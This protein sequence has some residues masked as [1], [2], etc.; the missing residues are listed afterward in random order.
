MLPQKFLGL[1][2]GSWNPRLNATLGPL[3]TMAHCVVVRDNKSWKVSA[4]AVK[5][6]SWKV[7]RRRGFS[8][9]SADKSYTLLLFRLRWM[10]L[11]VAVF[12]KFTALYFFAESSVT[13]AVL[14]LLF[15]AD[16]YLVIKPINS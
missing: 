12:L 14:L 6:F 10:V 7:A 4:D 5:N 13:V 1:V 8:G 11:A 9:T 15:F 2:D 16:E 3:D